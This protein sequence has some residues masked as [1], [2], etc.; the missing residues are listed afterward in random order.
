MMI[1]TLLVSVTLYILYTTINYILYILY[2]LRP[3]DCEW[4]GEN[5]CEGDLVEVE[6]PIFP[7]FPIFFSPLCDLL[8]SFSLV[9]TE[10]G[11]V[12][13]PEG[14]LSMVVPDHVHWRQDG[15]FPR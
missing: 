7:N 11:L 1:K 9:K 6:N 5:Y 10:I 2:M 13:S 3:G 4:Y 15:I 14:S 12:F 8:S